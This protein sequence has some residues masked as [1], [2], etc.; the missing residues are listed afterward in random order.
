M[1]GYRRL[2]LRGPTRASLLF[3]YLR[4]IDLADYLHG[5]KSSIIGR[6]DFLKFF[7]YTS[8]LESP[9]RL[10]HSHVEGA[11]ILRRSIIAKTFS[12]SRCLVVALCSNPALAFCHNSYA[13]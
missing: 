9:Q 10:D 13:K 6:S 7:H 4:K 11:N 1:G 5:D 12:P 3:A 8:M 2:D